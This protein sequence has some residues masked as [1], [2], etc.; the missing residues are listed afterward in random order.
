MLWA[1]TA[2]AYSAAEYTRARTEVRRVVK[3]APQF[4]P[5]S[6]LIMLT[7]LE[8]FS[9]MFLRWGP[10]VRLRSSVTQVYRLWVESQP[11]ALHL[12][13][14]LL[15]CKSVGQV[16]DRANSFRLAQFQV[17]AGEVAIEGGNVCFQ[18]RLD[19]LIGFG[20]IA[21]STVVRVQVLA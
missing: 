1:Q 3:F 12:Y 14:Q 15:F 20:C 2:A 10:N 17:P 21:D 8:V 18:D 5:V 6:F 19:L 16:V 7:R 11:F 4:T 9:A 13:F